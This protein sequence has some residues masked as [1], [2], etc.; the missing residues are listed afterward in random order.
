MVYLT[1]WL[2]TAVRTLF[3]NVPKLIL[4]FPWTDILASFI[5]LLLTTNHD[6]LDK[7]AHFS[8]SKGV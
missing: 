6:L 5:P 4:S 2:L 7:S 1:D 3:V 8:F